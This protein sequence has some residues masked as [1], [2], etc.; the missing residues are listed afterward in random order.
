MDTLLGSSDNGTSSRVIVASDFIRVFYAEP[1]AG[2][3]RQLLAAH[4]ELRSL[5]GPDPSSALWTI[6]LVAAQLTLAL[7]A[8]R[9]RWYVWVPCAYV[10][11]ATLDHA[12]WV[13]IHESSHNL[14]FRSRTGNRLVA[15]GANIPLVIPA[16]L[17]FCK[18][19][20][21]H[22][23]HLGD[24]NLDAGVPGPIESRVVGRSAP[25]KALWIAAFVIVMGIVRPL[26][27]RIR[28]M[29]GWTFAN[30]VVQI[31]MMALLIAFTGMRPFWYLTVSTVCAIGLHPLGAR[32]IQ[33]HF[34]LHEGQETYS[35]YGPL[36]R[37]AFNIGYHNEHH[38]L[39]TVSWSR[40]PDVRRL[41]PEF[42]DE[43]SSYSSWTAL[44]WRFLAD[45]SVSLFNYIVR[46]DARD[47]TADPSVRG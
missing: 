22:H 14:V 32:W 3:G 29:D 39:V 12:L 20:L 36:N 44:L 21:L 27:L 11:G 34:A 24:P 17:S 13:M 26:R 10:V 6:G 2:R 23:R 25:M 41:A 38:D 31:A 42:Y 37:L 15:I 18:Y 1:H 7:V 33:E 40:L 43:L 5:A 46:P 16:A 35:Y 4:P 30:I 28:L 47:A 8:T 9:Y 19:H 45:G